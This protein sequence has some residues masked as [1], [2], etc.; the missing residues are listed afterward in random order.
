MRN[1]VKILHEGVC[2]RFAYLSSYK[3]TSKYGIMRDEFILNR[4]M[5]KQGDK[6]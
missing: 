2:G 3:E 6:K 4:K 1:L 5:E